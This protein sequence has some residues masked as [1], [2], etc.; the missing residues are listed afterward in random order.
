MVQT[1]KDQ[2]FQLVFSR[3]D[4]FLTEGRR[5][6]S[7][8]PLPRQPAPGALRGAGDMSP[9]CLDCS[10]ELAD[11]PLCENGCCLCCPCGLTYSIELVMSAD[12][13]KWE[14]V[15]GQRAFV[16]DGNDLYVTVP[17]SDGGPI[18]PDA[19]REAYLELMR[20]WR[21]PKQGGHL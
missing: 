5:P 9:R 19:L 10:A 4:W 12:R 6:G 13:D 20:S 1:H 2:T 15:R 3:H 21:K 8:G 14:R 18:I 11:A 7:P 17:A 16:R